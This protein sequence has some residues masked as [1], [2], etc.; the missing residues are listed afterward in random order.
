[1]TKAKTGKH[2]RNTMRKDLDFD[3]FRSILEGEKTT[4]IQRIERET[5]SLST[6]PDSNPDLLDAAVKTTAQSRRVGWIK[7]LRGRQ[8]QIE[9]ALQR[10]DTGRYGIC[11]RCGNNIDVDRL[12]AKPYARYCIKCKKK[13]EK[14]Y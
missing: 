8:T 3:K 4:I 6:Y 2:G 13:I 1:V 11:A 5:K 12:E 10:L 9:V 14:G 7:Y